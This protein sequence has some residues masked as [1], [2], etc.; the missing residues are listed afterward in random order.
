MSKNNLYL[1][2]YIFLFILLFSNNYLYSQ[3]ASQVEPKPVLSAEI[4]VSDYAHKF[5]YI[6]KYL[7]VFRGLVIN[8]SRS[9]NLYPLLNYIFFDEGKSDIPEWYVLLDV[10]KTSSFSDTTLIGDTMDKYYN[11]LNIYAYRLIHNP[12]SKLKIIGCNDNQSKSEQGNIALSKA[13]ALSVLNYFK[14]VW[15]ID[16]NR[17]EVSWRNSPKHPTSSKDDPIA[18]QENRRV[19]IICDAWCI[20]KPFF[21]Y[22]F[23]RE[24]QPSTMNFNMNNSMNDE[25]IADRRIE[26]KIGNK[27]WITLSDIGISEIQKIWN[28][29][30]IQNKLPNTEEPF[31]AQLIITNKCCEEF[32]SD[33]IVIPVYMSI[34]M[35]ICEGR[36]ELIVQEK[37]ITCCCFLLIVMKLLL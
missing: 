23:V 14:N 28:W 10:D 13:R 33:S 20:V 29:K 3:K 31:T 6:N 36:E 4:N 27:D 19:E 22:S 18:F 8:E 1:Y 30:N 26:I 34:L 9:R 15:K 24:A 17:I 11:L 7:A 32:K 5:K 35:V 25:L 16:E 37:F 21:D 2:F 12:N